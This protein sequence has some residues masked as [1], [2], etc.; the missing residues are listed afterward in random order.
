MIK[1]P[2]TVS[3]TATQSERARGL[4]KPQ[5]CIASGFAEYFQDGSVIAINL[6]KTRVEAQVKQRADNSHLYFSNLRSTSGDDQTAYNLLHQLGIGV[7]DH[8]DIFIKDEGGKRTFSLVA[9]GKL[10]TNL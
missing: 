3:N 4:E 7:G 2:T 1:I 8:P 9:Q 5:I 10:E 6:G